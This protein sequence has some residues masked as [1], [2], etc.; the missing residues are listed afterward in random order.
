M[1]IPID[2]EQRLCL[3]PASVDISTTVILSKSVLEIGLFQFV[4]WLL[5]NTH[6]VLYR[7]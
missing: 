7:Y 3:H 2:L 1:V 6:D 5:N 4:I